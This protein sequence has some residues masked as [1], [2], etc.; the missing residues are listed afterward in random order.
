MNFISELVID[1]NKN[2]SAP[3]VGKGFQKKLGEASP[4]KKRKKWGGK[5]KKVGLISKRG[6]GVPLSQPEK[7]PKNGK[8]S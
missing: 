8:F 5:T 4:K 6:G 1:K 7:T 2:L 3:L